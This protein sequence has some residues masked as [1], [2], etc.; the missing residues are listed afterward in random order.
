MPRNGDTGT[1]CCVAHRQALGGEVQDSSSA[2][3]RVQRHE[4]TSKGRLAVFA[5]SGACDGRA[6]DESVKLQNRCSKH[7]KPI[8]PSS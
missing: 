6:A 2:K 3:Y 7:L 4:G 1:G 8:N 5:S